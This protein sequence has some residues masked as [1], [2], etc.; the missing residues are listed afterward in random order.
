[1]GVSGQI[2]T[3]VYNELSDRDWQVFGKTGFYSSI[4]LLFLVSLALQ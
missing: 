3:E 2:A 4:N 1:M